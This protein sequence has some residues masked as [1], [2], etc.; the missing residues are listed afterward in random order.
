MATSARSGKTDEMVSAPDGNSS[1]ALLTSMPNVVAD[2]YVPVKVSF[3]A[4]AVASVVPLLI[5]FGIAVGISHAAGDKPSSKLNTFGDLELQWLCFSAVA[6]GI[7][8]R[9]LNFSPTSLK[10]PATEQFA[11]KAK[12]NIRANMYMFKVRDDG[13]NLVVL[14]EEGAAGAYNRAN[15]S[16]HHFV[17]NALPFF[18]TVPLAG[19]VWPLPVF[20]LTIVY[21]IGR[22]AHQVGYAVKG[23]G[24]HAPGFMLTILSGVIVEG[25]TLVAG[26]K[27]SGLGL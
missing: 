20:V 17:E 10:G 15:R 1:N 2:S 11:S 14:E 18:L 16:I 25:L 13:G 3:M 12:G 9:F 26:L 21:A 27:A 19:Y 24:A 4:P 5:G 22:V 8:P 7:V 6:L 23:Y